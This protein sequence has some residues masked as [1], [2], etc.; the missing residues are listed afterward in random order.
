MPLTIRLFR[1]KGPE[2]VRVS[3][4]GPG[5]SKKPSSPFMGRVRA[6]ATGLLAV[7]RRLML[8]MQMVAFVDF[9]AGIF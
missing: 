3:P 8:E 9:Q 7:L 4:L 6:T 1:S 5:T 2:R